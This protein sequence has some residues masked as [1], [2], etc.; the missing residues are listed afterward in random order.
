MTTIRE[1]TNSRF[2]K[3][4]I[5]GA[6]SVA[7]A[8]TSCSHFPSNGRKIA[9]VETDEKIVAAQETF[10]LYGPGAPENP[11]RF[12]NEVPIFS[13]VKDQTVIINAVPIQRQASAN[14]KCFKNGTEERQNDKNEFVIEA[15]DGDFVKCQ[16]DGTVQIDGG[17]L[18][19]ATIQVT[20]SIARRKIDS[21]EVNNNR[22]KLIEEALTLL[23]KENFSPNTIHKLKELGVLESLQTIKGLTIPATQKKVGIVPELNLNKGDFLS[24]SMPLGTVGLKKN[25]LLKP[26]SSFDYRGINGK[27]LSPKQIQGYARNAKNLLFPE[28]PAYSLVCFIAD[29]ENSQNVL[30]YSA[31]ESGGIFDAVQTSGYLFCAMNDYIRGSKKKDAYANN[32]GSFS[33]HIA[34]IKRAE[35]I[36]ELSNMKVDEALARLKQEDA[37]NKANAEHV[38]TTAYNFRLSNE[39][40]EKRYDAYTEIQLER[41]LDY[42]K[43]K[44][45]DEKLAAEKTEELKRRLEQEAKNAQKYFVDAIIEEAPAIHYSFVLKPGSTQHTFKVHDVT[46][47]Q[48]KT[49]EKTIWYLDLTISH[50]TLTYR[51]ANGAE[52]IAGQSILN[53]LKSLRTSNHVSTKNADGTQVYPEFPLQHVHVCASDIVDLRNRLQALASPGLSPDQS[54][55]WKIFN[56]FHKPLEEAKNCSSKN[57]YRSTVQYQ[58]RPQYKFVYRIVPAQV[59]QGREK[60]QVQRWIPLRIEALYEAS[61]IKDSRWITARNVEQHPFLKKTE[62]VTSMPYTIETENDAVAERIIETSTLFPKYNPD[63]IVIPE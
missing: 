22:V 10:T 4:F 12:N 6:F 39:H 18:D 29:K 21:S 28:A 51:A 60:F 23:D 1:Q 36:Q 19:R 9:S 35:V 13:G 58:R 14:I 50:E 2:K 5:L 31:A 49:V 57:N 59:V 15:R 40:M 34:T 63:G 32:E 45:R 24:F 44:A 48:A 54:E 46:G 53:A 47:S 7:L 33:I 41:T 37:L 62:I 8:V 16:Y 56:Q 52:F 42:F 43:Q 38:K 30:V 17:N 26:N 61:E 27:D 55:Y 20:Y 25:A 3:L 11:E